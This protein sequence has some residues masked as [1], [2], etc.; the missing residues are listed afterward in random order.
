M[1]K[2]IALFLSIT[3][4]LSLMACATKDS[5]SKKPS[6]DS[7]DAKYL[8]EVSFEGEDIVIRFALAKAVVGDYSS[9]E[10]ISCLVDDLIG[11]TVSDNI[12]RRNEL[13]KNQLGDELEVCIKKLT[14]GYYVHLQTNEK[15]ICVAGTFINI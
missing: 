6:A 14:D 3:F 9:K 15:E 4:M 7:P 10:W 8:E 5:G 11:E 2:I 1:K 12:Y 13:I